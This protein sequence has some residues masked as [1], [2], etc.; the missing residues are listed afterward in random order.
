MLLHFAW[1]SE[2]IQPEAQTPRV[3]LHR[4]DSQAST[5]PCTG[6]SAQ[7][8]SAEQSPGLPVLLP[9]EIWKCREL[10]P[11]SGRALGWVEKHG[12]RW[13]PVSSTWQSHSM[14]GSSETRCCQRLVWRSTFFPCP[15]S[16]CKPG[17]PCSDMRLI[18]DVRGKLTAFSFPILEQ[19]KC[20]LYLIKGTFFCW[21]FS[22]VNGQQLK[23]L[24]SAWIK[25][26]RISFL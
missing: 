7:H 25:C 9:S 17:I 20:S 23:C 11:V 6:L 13:A 24:P 5:Q 12:Q 22:Y 10:L 3:Q 19:S 26:S 16:Y 2:R 4:G 1:A 15:Q 18:L 8:R 14:D 21:Y